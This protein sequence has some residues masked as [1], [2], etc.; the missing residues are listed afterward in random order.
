M[1]KKLLIIVVVIAVFVAGAAWKIWSKQPDG[2]NASGMIE[3]NTVDIMPKIPGYITDIKFDTGA[4]VTADQVAVVLDRPDLRANLAAAEAAVAQAKA[5]VQDLLN[6]PTAAQLQETQKEYQAVKA[7]YEQA[8]DNYIR[9]K[10][11]YGQGA[12][13]AQQMDQYTANLGLYK[14]MMLAL[15]ARNQQTK[16]GTREQQVVMAKE[17][18][19]QAQAQCSASRDAV[20]DMT[21][22]VPVNGVAMNRN[23]DKGEYVSPG[24][25]ITTIG[26]Y[27]DCW[28]KIY[29]PS[30]LLGKVKLGQ[31]CEVRI[32]SYPDRVFAGTVYEISQQAEFT[33]RMTITPSE[34][35]NLVYYVKVR[36]ENKEGVFKPGMPADVLIK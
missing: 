17:A 36:L 34:R 27:T 12:I 33:P 9:G 32:D 1:V 26:D 14:N 13:S 25:A 10:E 22:L 16:D 11:Q 35:A 23:F 19:N 7:L 24:A 3:V 2:I 30:T 29:I 15:E 4:K 5:H 8:N 21:L 6:G 20:R 18:L 31:K 28:V